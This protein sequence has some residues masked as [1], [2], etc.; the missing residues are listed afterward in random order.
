[1]TTPIPGDTACTWRDLADQ[2][3]AAQIASLTALERR[4][5]AT[6]DA[7]A[8]LF[9]LDRDHAAH[10]LAGAVMFGHLAAPHDARRIF[11]W[12]A[13]DRD[14]WSRGFGC[15]A[16]AAGSVAVTVIGEQLDDGTVPRAIAVDDPAGSFHARTSPPSMPSSCSSRAPVNIQTRGRS[17]NR[18]L[19]CPPSSPR[20]RKFK[21][22]CSLLPRS[23]TLQILDVKLRVLHHLR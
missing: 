20:Y 10:N 5:P 4:A 12:A 8:A 21:E 19:S 11:R 7:A 15:S 9:A 1:M 23:H 14:R 13:A 6:A 18:C 17:G 16:Q 2:L 3:T 22:S